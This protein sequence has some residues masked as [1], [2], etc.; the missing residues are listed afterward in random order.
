MYQVRL[1]ISSHLGSAYHTD[2]DPTRS[3]GGKMPRSIGEVV[4]SVQHYHI[5]NHQQKTKKQNISQVIQNDRLIPG[6]E[7]T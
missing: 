5:K 6:L 4:A 3:F 7:V 1:R 2:R